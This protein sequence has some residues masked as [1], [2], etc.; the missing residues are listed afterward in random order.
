MWP[1]GNFKRNYLVYQELRPLQFV[2][3]P[4]EMNDDI[5]MFTQCGH[6]DRA[7]VDPRWLAVLA[8]GEHIEIVEPSPR[9]AHSSI[10]QSGPQRSPLSSSK[11]CN[12]SWQVFPNTSAE[13]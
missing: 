2:D 4:E 1:L 10:E 11:P 5:V 3:A 8:A 6:I 13:A 12:T 7:Y 9:A